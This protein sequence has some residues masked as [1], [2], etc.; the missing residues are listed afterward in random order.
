MKNKKSYI[1]PILTVVL[2]K[3]EQGY[4]LSGSGIVDQMLFW[5]EENHNNNDQVQN[6]SR[7]D[8]W[9]NDGSNS[10]WNWPQQKTFF[11]HIGFI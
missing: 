1:T 10:F 7:H 8:D 3:A 5:Q 9:T 6:Y 2:F 11:G 4:A